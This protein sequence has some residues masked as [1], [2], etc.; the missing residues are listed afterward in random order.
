MNHNESHEEELLRR[1]LR[2]EADRVLPS[3]DA[4]ARIRRRTARAPF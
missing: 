2:E 4:L 1:A 3:A